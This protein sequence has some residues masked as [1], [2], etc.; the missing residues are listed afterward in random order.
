MITFEDFANTSDGTL[1]IDW[2]LQK[3]LLDLHCMRD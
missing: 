3:Q 1:H 2:G